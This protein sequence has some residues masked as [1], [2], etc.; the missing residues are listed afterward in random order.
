MSGQSWPVCLG[1]LFAA[2]GAQSPQAEGRGSWGRGN[3]LMGFASAFSEW[4]AWK[5]PGSEFSRSGLVVI[6]ARSKPANLSIIAQIRTPTK[7][8]TLT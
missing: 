5:R 3:A 6:R 2:G 8:A 1:G 7:Q 4:A